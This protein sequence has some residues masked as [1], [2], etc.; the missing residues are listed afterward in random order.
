MEM[1]VCVCDVCMNLDLFYFIVFVN[2]ESNPPGN[3]MTNLTNI[4]CAALQMEQMLRFHLIYIW[5]HF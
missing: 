5:L 2:Q 4:K 1:L 3:I